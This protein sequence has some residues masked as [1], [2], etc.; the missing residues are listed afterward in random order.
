MNAQIE[1]EQ[2]RAE[3]IFEQ[4]PAAQQAAILL[5]SQTEASR[6]RFVRLGDHT[7]N[8]AHI[9]YIDWDHLDRQNNR[10]VEITFLAAGSNAVVGLIFRDHEVEP[11]A[12]L[13]QEVLEPY[14]VAALD[15]PEPVDEEEAEPTE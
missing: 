2:D 10:C 4:L 8:L 5:K 1:A 15:F 6:L 12:A 11:V 13:L 14:T 3:A 9:A 7:I